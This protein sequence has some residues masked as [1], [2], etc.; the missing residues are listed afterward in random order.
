MVL[1]AKLEATE[2]WYYILAVAAFCFILTAYII[3]SVHF[4]DPCNGNM[5]S[6]GLWLLIFALVETIYWISQ[7][8]LSCCTNIKYKTKFSTIIIYIN[9]LFLICWS[10]TGAIDL[11]GY[12]QVCFTEQ[13]SLWSGSL[14]ILIFTW[15]YIIAIMF[16]VDHKSLCNN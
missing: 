6:L 9:C 5:I 10:I 1:M 11:F 12:S 8:I 14:A 7:I 2:C 15:I 3:G 4:Y 13:I 16:I